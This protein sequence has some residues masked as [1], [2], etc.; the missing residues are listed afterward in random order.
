[1]EDFKNTIMCQ[2]VH[3]VVSLSEPLKYLTNV[4]QFS[5]IR[6]YKDDTHLSLNTH[7][8]WV[9]EFYT[10]YYRHGICHKRYDAYSSAYFFH[11][12]AVDKV[13]LKVMKQNFDLNP[14]ITIVEKE[15][16]FCNLYS[17]TTS[18]VGKD[19]NYYTNNLATWYK[20]IDYFKAKSDNLVALAQADRQI[21]PKVISPHSGDIPFPYNTDTNKFHKA[22]MLV[23][24][25]GKQLNT[26]LTKQETLCLAYLSQ[27][28]TY[29]EVANHLY[30]S[31]KTV[32]THVKKSKQKLQAKNMAQLI[33]RFLSAGS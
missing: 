14:G 13:T 19:V 10:T 3:D 16:D 12:E 30:I 29:R 33:A 9:K 24:E 1:M 18:G 17:F 31:E 2:K 5:L 23:S 21:F 7:I 27:G 20:F 22:G 25:L 15:Q 11:Q 26:N 8:E 28:Y 6:I 4:N 32:E